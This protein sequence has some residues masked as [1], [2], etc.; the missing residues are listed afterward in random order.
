MTS[1]QS[2]VLENDQWVA[3]TISAEELMRD[4]GASRKRMGRQPPLKPPTCGL[5]TRTIIDSPIIRWVLPVQLRS[6]RYND[7]ALV[8]D[9]CVQICELDKERQFQDVAIKRDFNSRIRNAL[10][11]GPPKYPISD[12][13]TLVRS[14]DRDAH[15][16]DS[17]SQSYEWLE[18]DAQLFQ[19]LLVLVLERGELVFLFL[20]QTSIGG[21]EFVSSHHSIPGH[22][23]V[24]PGFHMTIDPSWSYLTV[25]CSEN[26]FIM[27]RLETMETLRLQQSQGQPL[28][29]IASTQ[30]RAVKGI[31]HKIEF[32]H[33]IPGN[34][35][36]VILLIIM[37]QPKFSKL[38]IY[39]WDHS[40]PLEDVFAEER[41]GHRLD[42]AYRMPLLIV[43]LVVGS[44]FLIITER[45]TATCSDVLSGPPIFVPFDLADRENTLLHHG[46]HQPLWTAWTRPERKP[47]F[48]AHKDVIYLAREDGFI[49]FLEIE[50]ESGIETSVSMGSVDCNIDSAFASVF[51]PFGDVLVAGGDSGPGAIWN[52]M[53]REHPQRIGPIPNWSPTVDLVVTSDAIRGAGEEQD[54]SLRTTSL[55]SKV[56]TTWLKPDRLFAC[57]GRGMMGAITEL[58]YGIQAKIGLDLKY[59][60]PIKQ[61][62]PLSIFDNTMDDGFLMLLALPNRSAILHFSLGFS[63]V[64][65]KAQDAV[66]FDLSSTTLA[67]CQTTTMTIQ[68]T[69]AYI[70]IITPTEYYQ[71]LT[72]DFTQEPSAAV[73]D[74]AVDHD[75]IAMA[76][77]TGSNFKVEILA[78]HDTLV[79]FTRAF[80]VEGE[81]TCLSIGILAGNVVVMAGIWQGTTSTL[82][83]Y[84]AKFSQQ[85]PESPILLDVQK[86]VIDYN[87]TEREGILN[88]TL[89]ALTSIVSAGEH[90]NK[91]TVIVGTRNGDVL[92][93][94]IDL[95]QPGQLVAYQ[96][97][98]G[99]SPSHAFPGVAFKS[100]SSV[101]I[102][103]DAELAIMTNYGIG[104]QGGYFED[105]Y[106]VW[107]TDAV[108][109]NMISPPINSVA[110]LN[111]IPSFGDSTLVMIAGS[112]ILIAE[113]QSQPKPVPRHMPVQGTPMKLIYSRWLNSLVTVVVKNGLPSLHFL[114]PT[115]GKDLS[116]PTREQD[117]N[118]YS[119]V[120]HITGLGTYDTKVVSLA[121]W[122]YRNSGA[123]W[124]WIVLAVR[125]GQN[126][127]LLLVV[128]TEPEKVST[129]TGSSRRI[130][131][132]TK[133]K[134]KITSAP[135]FSVTTD[136]HGLFLCAGNSLQYHTI[137][138]KKFK[139]ARQHELPSPATWMQVV[140]GRLHV[141][142]TKHSL[143]IL[144]YTT[145]FALEG[146]QMVQ[147]H[148]DETCRSGLHLIEV[149][150]FLSSEQRQSITM[151]SDPMCSVYGLW[152]PSQNER[153]LKL[154]FRAELQAS[155][156]RFARGRA[157]P[158]WGL[159]KSPPRYGC[160]Q[161][162]LDGSDI[163]GLSIDGSL[164]HFSLLSEDA[165][166]LL[167]YIQN[168]AMGSQVI[169]EYASGTRTADVF[170]VEPKLNP[171]LNMHVDGDI[172]QRCLDKHALEEIT[173]EPQHSR[174]LREL[175]QSLDGGKHTSGFQE[176][177]DKQ[178]YELAY[179]ILK[180]YLVPIL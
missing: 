113:L 31:I 76:V 148:T 168:L 160:I 101:L 3:R 59:S 36:Q 1:L 60:S 123:R 118:H 66:Q 34:D 93:L 167:R 110:R 43:P 152:S 107:P 74:A 79:T 96:D 115:T 133:F 47:E 174:R 105:K 89:S 92:T 109:P 5:L 140:D 104:A 128:S 68:I 35:R 161:S 149:G 141:L 7:V 48:Y 124:E 84:P 39:E 32:L 145:D 121:K 108:E 45:I 75:I 12:N 156:R 55:A 13:G 21:W 6:S 169:C 117:D 24:N 42:D 147:L 98:L 85:A 17:G 177:D 162:G 67:A 22:R 70:T 72:S 114:D 172:L 111:H 78:I 138:Q 179:R 180:Y 176:T 87:P 170:D 8:G 65:E 4:N 41:P 11:M 52:I 53:A 136:E 77:Y 27:Y 33:P 106:R 130:R 38:A 10:V 131:F 127:N 91:A 49:N 153:P 134:L 69:A 14:E 9:H 29:P 142:T 26:L 61:C 116:Y 137:E 99:Q 23:L 166:R 119:E 90:A 54:K 15:M 18:E 178:F 144:D 143:I 122:T 51:D 62:W 102:C 97:R 125:L 40:E 28:E 86:A 171:K 155:V 19:Q 46:T 132:W 2:Y 163:L 158:P 37:I 151:L 81:V 173:S 83:I 16:M 20:R 154:V 71:H 73:T 57:S 88:G 80:E 139:L 25:A 82:A 44:A 157:R 150:S 175:L 146:E 112:Q 30:A 165:W 58:R 103:N 95:S 63:E 100:S 64:S 50:D 56:A 135:L 94:H 120:D 126:R 159:I 164:Q 129:P